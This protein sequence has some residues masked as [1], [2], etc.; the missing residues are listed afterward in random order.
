V[1]G[2]AWDPAWRDE[3]LA[4]ACTDVRGGIIGAAR[5]VLAETRASWDFGRRGYASAL[6]GSLAAGGNLPQLWVKDSPGDPDALLLA[7]R[8][9]AARAAKALREKSVSARG[10][11]RRTHAVAG[12]A[13]RAWPQDPTPWVIVLGLRK[14]HRGGIVT[15]ATAHQVAGLVGPWVQ[16][17]RS[18]WTRDR[19]NREAGRHLMDYFSPRFGGSNAAMTRVAAY[20]AEGSPAASPLRLLPL[21]ACLECE[22]DPEAEAQETA[23]RFNRLEEIKKLVDG[24]TAEIEAVSAGTWVSRDGRLRP[25]PH[26]LRERRAKLEYERSKELRDLGAE[27]RRISATLGHDLANLYGHWLVRPEGLDPNGPAGYVP[28]ADVSLLA[29][30][31]HLAGE[32]DYA[33]M[34]LR[35]LRPCAS[36]YPWSL[37]GEPEQ[38]LRRTIK[39]LEKADGR[40]PD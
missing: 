35:H 23:T 21:A 5:E 17:E 38:V 26:D 20:L 6:L 11:V 14:Y 1:S 2:L 13:A 25:D 8:A 40:S 3:R 18:I 27:P 19:Y 10:L 36:R 33:R 16:V 7:A 12:A 22:P 24:I 4:A 15:C 37:Y 29:H 32:H 30:G 31:L 9:A 34:T 39:D 28:V